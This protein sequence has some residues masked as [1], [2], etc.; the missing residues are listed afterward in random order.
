MATEERR[1]LESWKEIAAYL[2]RSEKTCRRFEVSLGLPVHRLDGTPKARIFAYSDEIDAWLRDKLNHA[3]LEAAAAAEKEVEGKARGRR[4]MRAILILGATAPAALAVT[5]VLLWHPFSPAPGPILPRNPSLAVLPFDN[6]AKDAGLE[7]WRTGLADLVITDLVQ[8]RYV[9]VVRIT[10]LT[11]RLIELK[12]GE[13]ERFSDEDLRAIADKTRVDFI[14]T[15]RLVREKGAIAVAVEVRDPR[16][17]K[18]AGSF[19]TGYGQELGVFAAADR[20]ARGIKTA[21][22]LSRRHVARDIDR[23]AAR[24]STASPPAFILYSQGYRLAGIANYTASIQL[25]QRAVGLDPKFALAYR[26]LY[27]AC[28]NVGRAGEA[29]TYLQKARDL[30]GRLPERERDELELEFYRWYAEDPAGERAALER[31]NR[32]YPQ[33]RL[34]SRDLLSLYVR[35]EDWDKALAVAE[36][37]WPTNKSDIC[38]LLAICYIN[39]GWGEKAV[40]VLSEGIKASPDPIAA[41]LKRDRAWYYLQMDKVDEALAEAE[42]WL[43]QDPNEPE[44]LLAAGRIRLFNKDFPAAR[45]LFERVLEQDDPWCQLDALASTRDMLLMQGRIEA[46]K[47]PLQRGLEIAQSVSGDRARRIQPKVAGIH[48]ELSYLLELEGDLN[49]ALKEIDEAIGLSPGQPQIAHL[50]QKA[51]ILLEMDRLEGFAKLAEEIKGDVERSQRP[52]QMRAY[53]YLLGRQALKKG[54]PRKAIDHL[55]R[56]VDL[57]SV[58]GSFIDGADP[59]YFYYLAEAMRVGGPG[60]PD[61]MYEKV[62]RPSV[63][64][65]YKGDLYAMSLYRLA[66]SQDGWAGR[67]LTARSIKTELAKAAEYYRQF[68]ALWG[69]ADAMFAP[70]VEDARAR[71]AA[72]EKQLASF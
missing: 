12:L 36:A 44:G 68:L 51:V 50:A 5:A 19:R 42:R 32:V 66:K 17:T 27:R 54:D 48:K 10:E 65:T 25:L 4:R 29:K 15:G 57:V 37:S 45:R 59:E 46:A 22:G 16:T 2:Q 47:K 71:L 69:G 58:P 23:D 6:P 43:A 24:V 34:P 28:Q 13:I 61:L 56:A 39:Q 52:R 49:G 1:L 21:V 7:P 11:R 41:I 55:W 38:Q 67:S 30:S 9:N 53:H 20:I 72:I 18:A 31:I 64:R 40:A 63:N 26:Y 62:T 3:Q 14:A 60:V 33:D 35:L 70:V 8:S